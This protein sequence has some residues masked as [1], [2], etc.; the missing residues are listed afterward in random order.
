LHV[1][2]T[3]GAGFIGGHLVESMWRDGHRVTVLDDLSTGAA[4]NLPGEV[5]LV[6]GDV[7][8]AELVDRLVGAADG[9]LHLAAA[10][11]VRRI[12][13]DPATSLRVNVLGGETVLDACQRHGRRVLLT[14][15]SEVYGG[16]TD[17]PLA[18]DAA[19]EFGPTWVFRWS[20][21]AAK[22]IEE[23]SALARHR[24]GDL[25]V[26]I[27]RLFNT[28]GPR[29]SPAYGMVLPRMVGQ[30]R[31]GE[32]V[33]VYGDGKQTRAFCHVFDVVAA[34]RALFGDLGISGEVFNVGRPA[35]TTIV[36]LAERVIE[37]SGSSSTVTFVPF[38]QAYGP[39]FAETRRRVPDIAKLTAATGWTP[40]YD[41]DTIIDELCRGELT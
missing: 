32:P 6:R 20:Y 27:A 4:A 17:V 35:E 12:V 2:V 23:M 21:G 39:G 18:E 10:V 14:S 31:R 11:G 36:E 33:T 8:D 38:E 30:A 41:L 29:Q 15:S 34:L 24:A 7:T 22:A 25:D 16:N 40:S 26:V 3:G 19:M 28:V 13:D 37:R 9:V 1:L 5:T